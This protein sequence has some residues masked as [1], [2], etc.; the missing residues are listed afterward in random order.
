LNYRNLLNRHIG[1]AVQILISIHTIQLTWVCPKVVLLCY[2]YL[3]FYSVPSFV[4]VVGV[5]K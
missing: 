4:H 1:C 5:N 2:S 3:I